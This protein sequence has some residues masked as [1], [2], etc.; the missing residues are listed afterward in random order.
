M[1]LA[2]TA[3]GARQNL[4]KITQ[5]LGLPHFATTDRNWQ[6]PFW[7]LI[8]LKL[9][10]PLN[11]V[12]HG[13]HFNH[14]IVSRLFGLV[15]E[16]VPIT[17]AEIDF[18][19]ERY[20]RACQI[21]EAVLPEFSE[22]H[23]LIGIATHVIRHEPGAAQSGSNFAM[24]GFYF[25][26]IS[27]ELVDVLVAELVVHELT[28]NWLFFEELAN[29]LF[30]QHVYSCE[31]NITAAS[32]LKPT[33]RRFDQAFHALAVAITTSYF[34]QKAGLDRLKTRVPIISVA[35][36]LQDIVNRLGKEGRPI[37]TDRGVALLNQL[38][39]FHAKTSD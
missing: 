36:E 16:V 1:E 25:V 7:N 26:S 13:I 6:V 38:V 35:I 21:V 15:R 10:S 28:H 34:R 22:I 20:F 31:T 19:R 9:N 37:L 17:N 39:A 3:E 8:R 24:P 5:D 18:L 12:P 27:D 14:P 29:G 4:V 33:R 2:I 30:H 23:S 32:P 11:L